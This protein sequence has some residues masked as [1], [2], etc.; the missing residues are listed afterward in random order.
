MTPDEIMGSELPER[1][2]EKLYDVLEEFEYTTH[3]LWAVGYW[4]KSRGDTRGAKLVDSLVAEFA[5]HEARLGGDRTTPA[6]PPSTRHAVPP[7]ALRRATEPA[8]GRGGILSDEA[9]L[10][11]AVR[12]AGGRKRRVTLVDLRAAIGGSSKAQD[13]AFLRLADA[14]RVVLYRE[15]SNS[16]REREGLDAGALYVGG[17]PRHILLVD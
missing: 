7:P 1:S 5:A 10:D 2:T 14:G 6:P 15:D 4:L 13:E 11:T 12:L 3:A 8:R 16:R 17:N 9:I